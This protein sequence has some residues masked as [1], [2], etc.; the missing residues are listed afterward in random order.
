MARGTCGGTDSPSVPPLPSHALKIWSQRVMMVGKQGCSCRAASTV[1]GGCPPSLRTSAVA[2]H[3]I[4]WT[5]AVQVTDLHRSKAL[6]SPDRS[7]GQLFPCKQASVQPGCF[8]A[9][10]AAWPTI[11]QAKIACIRTLNKTSSH[12]FKAWPGTPRAPLPQQLGGSGAN[13]RQPAAATSQAQQA[14]QEQ[15]CSCGPPAVL[16]EGGR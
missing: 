11:M 5:H 16:R 12:H 13:L 1:S 9:A 7:K 4:H 15:E 2:R 3:L 8:A 10:A 14:G 6:G